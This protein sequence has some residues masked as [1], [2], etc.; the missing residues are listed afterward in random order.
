MPHRDIREVHVL[1]FLSMARG[2]NGPGGIIGIN[3]T[4]YY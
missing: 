2:C 1:E 4:Y 3:I